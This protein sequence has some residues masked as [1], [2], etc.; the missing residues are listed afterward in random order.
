MG[1]IEERAKQ[2]E[3]QH[4]EITSGNAD[5]KFTAKSKAEKEYND[6]IRAMNRINEITG[7]QSVN[8]EAAKQKLEKATV[9]QY[10]KLIQQMNGVLRKLEQK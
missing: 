5:T 9:G 1:V 3:E 6:F 2:F 7:K 4:I 10:V 8:V